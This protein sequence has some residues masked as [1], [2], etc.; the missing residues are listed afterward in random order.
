MAISTKP[1]LRK[2]VSESEI[3]AVIN[4]GGSPTKSTAA[5]DPNVIKNFNIRLNEEVLSE[6]HQLKELRP[7]KVGS[8]RKGI[9]VHDWI[10][11]AILDKIDK[12]NKVHK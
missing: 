2:L 7:Q 11:E 8:R 12:E 3:D 9:S 5:A 6:I 1:P 4:K 10:L